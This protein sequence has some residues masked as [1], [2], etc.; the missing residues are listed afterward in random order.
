MYGL[1]YLGGF[2]W[3]LYCR[4]CPRVFPGTAQFVAK[5]LRARLVDRRGPSHCVP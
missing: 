4:F 1:L 3:W 5:P 2:Q